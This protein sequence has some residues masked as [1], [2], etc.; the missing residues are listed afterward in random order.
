MTHYCEVLAKLERKLYTMRNATRSQYNGRTNNKWYQ[1]LPQVIETLKDE[2][3]EDFTK[4]NLIQWDKEQ[5]FPLLDGNGCAVI[6][7]KVLV[8]KG[9]DGIEQS[10]I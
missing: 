9:K 6:M 5:K 10:K 1:D 3:D 8:K 4:P 7:P 2:P